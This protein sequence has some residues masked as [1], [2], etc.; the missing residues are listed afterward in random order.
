MSYLL[1]QALLCIF[2]QGSYNVYSIGFAQTLSV[3]P[4]EY[5]VNSVWIERKC[6][7]FL[8]KSLPKTKN[9]LKTNLM[10]FFL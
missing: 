1:I 2:Q 10:F 7:T 8:Q 6:R 9:I 4:I 3:V 5:G